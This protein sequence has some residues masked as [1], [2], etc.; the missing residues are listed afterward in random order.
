MLDN[1]ALI[2]LAKKMGGCK[3]NMQ[4]TSTIHENNPDCH[5]ATFEKIA[6]VL[7][8]Q[9]PKMKSTFFNISMDAVDICHTLPR[10]E[11]K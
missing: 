1:T 3:L 6:S 4:R 5:A 2:F 10:T 11:I 9:S 7:K 8:N